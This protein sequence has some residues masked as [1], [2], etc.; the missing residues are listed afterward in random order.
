[1]DFQ[2]YKYFIVYDTYVK[3]F[4]NRTYMRKWKGYVSYKSCYKMPIFK[5]R[6]CLYSYALFITKL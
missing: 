5:D 6:N 2:L 1:M 3:I 4:E